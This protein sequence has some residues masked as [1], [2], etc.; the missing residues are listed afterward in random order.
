MNDDHDVDELQCAD[1][2]RYDTF[3]YRYLFV[4][5]SSLFGYVFGSERERERGNVPFG[6]KNYT[7]T[8][9]ILMLELKQV[10]VTPKQK[11]LKQSRCVMALSLKN[12]G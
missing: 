10:S 6:R 7:L 1:L 5:V 8:F 2:Q 11:H 3:Q 12:G 9:I 4:V